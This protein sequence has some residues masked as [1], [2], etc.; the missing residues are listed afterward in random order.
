[1]ADCI[2]IAT[3]K[4]PLALWQAHFVR[5]QLLHFYP[6]LNVEL[7]PMVTEGDVLLNSP[8][9]KIGGKG[10]F[11][12]KLEQAILDKQAD[13]A[14]HS[15]KDIPIELTPN[16][17][18]STICARADRRD[19]FVSRS[20][21]SLETLPKG[22]I[23]GTS[24]LRR[25]A[26]LLARYPHLDIRSLRG[27][28]G[29]RLEKLDSGEY[30]AIILAAAGLI[31][32]NLEDRITQYLK[33]AL[34]LPAVGQGAIGI[35]IRRDDL[36]LHARLVALSDPKTRLEIEAER[37]MNAVLQG[38]CQV[39]IACLT[40]LNGDQLHLTGLVLSL[41]GRDRVEISDFITLDFS[42][43]KAIET[44]ILQAQELGQKVG[45]ALLGQG[46]KA[47]LDAIL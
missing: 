36:Q 39:P 46:A 12:K 40:E 30:D 11:I 2:K 45:E 3:R 6:D 26:Q 17:M 42:E 38:G 23:V 1:M 16:L 41:N 25:Q 35:E 37:A 24:S 9:S 5:D 31:R 18:L 21:S 32:L 27:N 20:Y 14:V 15:M 47:I 44:A 10:L 8:L 7:V 33:P 22:A 34:M 43:G 29:S 13:I 28:V 4:S 19:A